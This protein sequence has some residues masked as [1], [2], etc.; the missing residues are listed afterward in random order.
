MPDLLAAVAATFVLSLILASVLLRWRCRRIGPPFARHARPWAVLIVVATA[1]ASAGAGLLL[2][3]V[4]HHTVAAYAGLVVAAGLRFA[5]VP[6]RGNRDLRPRS[7]LASLPTLPFSRLYDRMGD[8]M[9]EW[10]DIRIAAAR[11]KPQ[12]IADA[13]LYYWGQVRG[14]LKD[15]RELAQ[16]SWL[17]ESI[18]HKVG[19][20][21]LIY[22]DT[23]PELVLQALQTQAVTKGRRK[24]TDEDLQRLGRRLESDALNELNLFLG[25][26]Y[27][28]GIY[29]LPIYPS[30]P[31]EPRKTR[32]AV[33]VLSA[34]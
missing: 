11:P 22:L 32:H 19:I 6:P 25:Y 34:Q 31:P 33:R 24:Y 16:L 29:K 15:D 17:R 12:W 23:S 30:R 13:A 5:N 18:T 8:D 28:S 3:A 26:S 27:R 7:A 1:I 21:R 4:S 9:R 2:A 20:I 10:C 14:R